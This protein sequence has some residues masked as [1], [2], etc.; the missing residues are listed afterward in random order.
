VSVKGIERVMVAL[1]NIEKEH[2]EDLLNNELK[3]FHY[4]K[5]GL[6]LFC[7]HGKE[8]VKNIS[9]KYD[10][11]IFL[12]LKLH[13]I[14][15]TVSKSIKSLRGLDIAFLTIHLSGGRE[16]IKAAMASANEHLPNTKLLGVS[17][18]T[19][20]ENKD[21][22]EMYGIDLNADAFNKL[23][24]LAIDTNIHGVVC[25]PHEAKII[26]ELSSEK[27]DVITVCPGIRFN[28]EIEANNIQDQKRV[29][30]P[31]DAFNSGSDYLVMGRSLT[32]ATDIKTRINDLC[33]IDL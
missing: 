22:N 15:N 4:I 3:D 5:I 13:D 16:M 21:L 7:A 23:F 24:N 25:S 20:L 29:L 26:K 8:W 10:K 14:P 1:D 32:Q 18:L 9:K 2:V 6:E 27:H 12:D 28:D 17:Y 31:Q 30:A 11:K 33:E 19:S